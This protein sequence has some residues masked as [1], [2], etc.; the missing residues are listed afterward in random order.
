MTDVVTEYIKDIK[1]N[2]FPSEKESY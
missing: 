2:D 1:S